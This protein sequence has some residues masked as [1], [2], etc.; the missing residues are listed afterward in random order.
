MYN[1]VNTLVI[2][3]RTAKH[4]KLLLAVSIRSNNYV[5]LPEIIG[6]GFP[7]YCAQ[8]FYEHINKPLKMG[9]RVFKEEI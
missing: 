8:A 9:K 2:P 6:Y 3:T 1:L 7:D 5:K 4:T